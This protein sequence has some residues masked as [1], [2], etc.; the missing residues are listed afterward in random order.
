MYFIVKVKVLSEL[1][2]KIIK[3]R[4]TLE[5]AIESVKEESEIYV[6]KKNKHNFDETESKNDI[7]DF[8]DKRVRSVK[9]VKKYNKKNSNIIE[10]YKRTERSIKGWIGSSREADDILVGYF[11]YIKHNFV[12]PDITCDRC[13][14]AVVTKKRAPVFGNGPSRNPDMIQALKQNRIFQDAKKNIEYTN[15]QKEELESEFEM[16]VGL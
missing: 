6:V 2:H 5:S 4:E 3:E 14:M 12:K 10:I 1:K 15:L 8:D 11:C 9:Y 13:Q 16:L 7:D